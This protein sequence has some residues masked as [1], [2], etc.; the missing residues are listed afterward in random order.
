[1]LLAYVC[2]PAIAPPIPSSVEVKGL[3][4]HMLLHCTTTHLSETNLL[5]LSNRD[6]APNHYTKGYN[7]VDPVI[8]LM[9]VAHHWLHLVILQFFFFFA[10]FLNVIQRSTWYAGQLLDELRLQ[11][12]SN[13]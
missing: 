10:F 6:L 2:I 4:V 8:F 9:R 1:L 5:P 12:H 13:S 7:S 3:G 11:V